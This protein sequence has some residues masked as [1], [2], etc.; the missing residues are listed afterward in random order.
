VTQGVVVVLALVAGQDAVDATANHLREGVLGQVR[1][2]GVIEG[3]GVGPGQADALVELADGEQPGIAGQLARR[4]LADQRR[5]EEI[6]ALGPGRRYT[7][8]RLP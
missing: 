5:A 1:V 3:A 2:A 6:E 7:Q 4:R 8:R